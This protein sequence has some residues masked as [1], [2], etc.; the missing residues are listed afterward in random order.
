MLIAVVLMMAVSCGLKEIGA[1]LV[2]KDEGVWKGP[3][4]DLKPGGSESTKRTIW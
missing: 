3:G 2:Q 4:A 1:E